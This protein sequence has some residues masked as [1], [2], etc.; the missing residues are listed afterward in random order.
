MSWI[1]LQDYLSDVAM[2]ESE[3]TDKMNR[4]LINLQSFFNNQ[5]G[6]HFNAGDI[7]RY[8]EENCEMNI[9]FGIENRINGD[10]FEGGDEH[11]LNYAIKVVKQH[12]ENIKQKDDEQKQNEFQDKVVKPTM[13]GMSDDEFLAMIQEQDASDNFSE[14]DGEFSELESEI[15]M[16]D[17]DDT[18]SE[19]TNG[20]VESDNKLDAKV[21]S[22]KKEITD[23]FNERLAELEKGLLKQLLEIKYALPV[24]E[25]QSSVNEPKRRSRPKMY[26]LR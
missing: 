4:S 5:Y 9:H 7:K 2:L 11:K 13:S 3:F 21:E 1:V 23:K 6:E 8:I 10:G 22:V 20:G 26:M 18:K 17:S 19:N 16:N 15:Q 24:E 25:V 12:Y 14:F